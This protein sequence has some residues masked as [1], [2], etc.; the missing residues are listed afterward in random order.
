MIDPPDGAAQ[1]NVTFPLPA[2]VIRSVGTPG[3]GAPEVGVAV[4]DGV[5]IPVPIEL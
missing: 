1:D 4:I 2:A 5:W 3:T